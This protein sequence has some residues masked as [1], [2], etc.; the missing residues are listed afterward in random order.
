MTLARTR[1]PAEA[2]RAAVIDAALRVFSDGSYSGATTADIAREAG[3]SEPILYRHFGCKRDLYLA[4]I[5]D[6]WVRLRSAVEEGVAAESDPGA[7]PLAVAKV[8]QRRDRRLPVHLW[9][10]AVSQAGED[11]EVR[12]FLRRHM[13][14]VHFFF[15]GLMRRSQ[16]AGGIPP[17]RDPDTEAWIG[18]GVG[19]LRSVQDALGGLL[20]TEDF[21]AIAASRKAWLTGQS[22]LSEAVAAE[23]RRDA[24]EAKSD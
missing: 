19:L 10:Q 20:T 24:R 7:W 12:R 18:L 14:E 15:A 6:A 16:E 4:C 9:I 23:A 22:P 17:D 2:R 3:V 1:L 13:K 11:P 8:L 21:E 5:D